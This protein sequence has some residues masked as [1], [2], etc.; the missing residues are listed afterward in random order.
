MIK[1]IAAGLWACLVTLAAS[2]AAM[3]WN[4]GPPSAEREPEKGSIELVRTRM[5]SVP[6]IRSGTLQGY[7]MAQFSFTGDAATLKR[8]PVKA[9][10]VVLD[11]AFRTIY[12]E[13]Q[14]DFRKLQKQDLGGLTKRIIQASNDRLGARVIED[15]FIQEFSYLTK[16][17][18][19][20]G[21]YRPGT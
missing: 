2:Y 10:I 8:I 6:V 20:T 11:E 21:T 16:D 17:G 15:V 18:V 14:L 5:I 12:S 3:S 13:D 19:R 1:L 7:V 4:A 9:D